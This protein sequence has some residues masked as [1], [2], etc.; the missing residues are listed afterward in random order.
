MRLNPGAH[1]RAPSSPVTISVQPPA[2]GF[3]HQ[4]LTVP[5]GGSLQLLRFGH[6]LCNMLEADWGMQG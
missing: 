4:P 1:C 3:A 2:V 6:R 5:G